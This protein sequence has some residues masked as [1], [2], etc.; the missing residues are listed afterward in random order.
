[1]RGPCW[2]RTITSHPMAIQG[3]P[4][5]DRGDVPG[6]VSRAANQ[7]MPRVVRAAARCDRAAGDV[8]MACHAAALSH[9]ATQAKAAALQRAKEWTQFCS[10]ERIERVHMSL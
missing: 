3:M 8:G 2:S 5:G 1:M 10:W 7:H 9:N 6:P 4:G